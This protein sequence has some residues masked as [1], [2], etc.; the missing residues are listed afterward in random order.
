MRAI[1][2]REYVRTIFTL[3]AMSGMYHTP[4][5]A[6]RKVSLQKKL[7]LSMFA[8]ARKTKWLYTGNASKK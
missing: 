6:K 4:R 2:A 8:A 5:I 3:K 1:A 7:D